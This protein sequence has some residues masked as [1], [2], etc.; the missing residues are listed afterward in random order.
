MKKDAFKFSFIFLSEYPIYL[1]MQEEG[2][3][4]REKRKEE[5]QEKD[6]DLCHGIR[7]TTHRE[8]AERMAWEIRRLGN[9][10]NEAP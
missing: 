4:R 10:S 5:E 7:S 2:R 3:I 1:N 6:D 9:S 8:P